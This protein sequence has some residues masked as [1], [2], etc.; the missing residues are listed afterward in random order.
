[1]ASSIVFLKNS[2]LSLIFIEYSCVLSNIN[3]FQSKVAKTYYYNNNYGLGYPFT[4]VKGVFN[5]IAIL[6]SGNVILKR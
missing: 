3:N 4:L 6:C 2:A 5:T 1:M